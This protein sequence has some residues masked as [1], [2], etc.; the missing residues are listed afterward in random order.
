MGNS[1]RGYSFQL[2]LN[3]TEHYNLQ[4]L[5]WDLVSFLDSW[6]SHDPLN[7]NAHTPIFPCMGHAVCNERDWVSP[8]MVC[9]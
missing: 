3:R 7:P 2:E 9:H 1:G 4:F 6:W 5:T 8:K